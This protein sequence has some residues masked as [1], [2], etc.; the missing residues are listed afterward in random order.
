MPNPRKRTHRFPLPLRHGYSFGILRDI[1][2][3]SAH[4]KHVKF[5]LR[6]IQIW[7][8]LLLVQGPG[9]SRPQGHSALHKPHSLA[10]RPAGIS[11]GK[12]I[13]NYDMIKPHP[14]PAIVHRK[15]AF[16]AAAL[17]Q[18][19]ACTRT[20]L[21][22]RRMARK[23]E[24]IGQESVFRAFG[25]TFVDS[26]IRWARQHSFRPNRR[27]GGNPKLEVGTSRTLGGQRAMAL[28]A[29]FVA[30]LAQLGCGLGHKIALARTIRHAFPVLA[31]IGTAHALGRPW[32]PTA[33]GSS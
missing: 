21:S 23:T 14:L 15:L 13:S 7:T 29:L 19:F 2:D 31:E 27:I 30:A 5:P 18:Q 20:T 11:T 8:Q 9:N 6:S 3:K 32:A 25:N 28:P 16:V 17:T 1:C 4:A 12:C 26:A 22:A 10:L 33:P 24:A